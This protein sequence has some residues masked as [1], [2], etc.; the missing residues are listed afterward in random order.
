M[1]NLQILVYP[2]PQNPINKTLLNR[3]KIKE[4]LKDIQPRDYHVLDYKYNYKLS[5]LIIRKEGYII[6]LNGIRAIVS[7]NKIYIFQDNENPDL[8]FYNHLMF[9]FNNQNIV[10]RDLPFEFKIL[11]IILIFICEKS[12]NIISNLSSKVNDISLQNVNSSK[13][14]TILKIQNDLLAFNLTYEEV[15]K[16]I[17]NLMKSEEDMFRIFLSKKFEKQ[18]E[19]DEIEKSK[20][21]ELEISLET[22]ENQIKED[23][24]QVTRLIREMQ[25]VLNLTEIKLAEFRNEIAIYNTKI[26]VFTLCTSF[27]AFFAS[28]FGMNLNNTFEESKGGLYVCAIIIIFIS[29]CL[30]QILNK[31]ITK[32]IKK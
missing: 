27:G 31:K 11:E 13:L 3:D 15:R 8:D 24:T 20:I 19:M 5:C 26:S 32:L 1:E 30:Y 29:G 17:F 2:P 9:Q 22:Y 21:D 7:K 18:I 4:I 14:S 6:K 16:I 28:I 10:S 12:D 25:A 23:L